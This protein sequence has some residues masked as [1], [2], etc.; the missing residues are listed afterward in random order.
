MTSIKATGDK[1]NIYRTANNKLT[2]H[3]Y[4]TY[5]RLILAFE[6]TFQ[7][8]TSIYNSHSYMKWNIENIYP[9][10]ITWRVQTEMKNIKTF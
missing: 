4:S 10:F 5:I 2:V 6:N 7:I 9:T 1:L 3:V 8:T